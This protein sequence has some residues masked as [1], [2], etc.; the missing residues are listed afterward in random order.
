M[1]PEKVGCSALTSQSVQVWWEPPLPEGRN[2]PLQ[3]Y[4][5]SHYPV[6]DWYGK[7]KFHYNFLILLS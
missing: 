4:K 5:V 6:E 3:G 1:A 2:G 7:I